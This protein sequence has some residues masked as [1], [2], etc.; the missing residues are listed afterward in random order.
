M[1]LT[2]TKDSFPEKNVCEHCTHFCVN[3]QRTCETF[4]IQSWTPLRTSLEV[5]CF[6]C[7]ELIPGKGAVRETELWSPGL[8]C[9]S[10]SEARRAEEELPIWPITKPG[11]VLLTLWNRMFCC[12]SALLCALEDIVKEQNITNLIE[13]SQL[14][15]FLFFFF[16]ILRLAFRYIKQNECS[17]EL[18]RGGGF[19]ERKGLKEAETKQKNQVGHFKVYVSFK[20]MGRETEQQKNN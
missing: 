1:N 11:L 7:V 3:F 10:E 14:F 19:I 2:E 4:E 16:A 9:S 13:Q 15:F 12:C 18:N 5:K 20:V 17:N 6:P 8:C